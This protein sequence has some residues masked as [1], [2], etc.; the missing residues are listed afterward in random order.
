[1]AKVNKYQSFDSQH[2]VDQQTVWVQW[3]L[4]FFIFHI[5]YYSMLQLSLLVISLY[6]LDIDS[7]KNLS[8]DKKIDN[9]PH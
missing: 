4:I 7:Q 3:R 1:M 5:Y 8:F 2:Q 6:P 9:T